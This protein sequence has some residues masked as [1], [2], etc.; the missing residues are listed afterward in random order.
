[1]CSRANLRCDDKRVRIVSPFA[2]AK[3]M[4]VH[5]IDE[6]RRDCEDPEAVNG[7]L[8]KELLELSMKDRSAIQEEIHG[9]QCLAIKE[10][11]KFIQIV[12]FELSLTLENDEI[13]QPHK[14]E[15]YRKSQQLPKSYVND[16]SFRLRFL[17]FTLF[18][19][20]KA[21]EKIV[22]FLDIVFELFGEFALERAVR[23]TDFDSRELK[24]LREGEIQF[25]PFRD[26]RG[27]RILVV[28]NPLMPRDFVSVSFTNI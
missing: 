26:R 18:D 27:R 16:N 12:L 10:S 5:Q 1:M 15:A 14:K 17:R 21:A 25:L 7:L 13:I 2:V 3:I 8:S 6:D 19:V 11:P 4:I 22:W 24:F 28:M 23:L 9:V 20:R